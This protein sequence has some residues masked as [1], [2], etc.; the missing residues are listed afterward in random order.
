[1][2]NPRSW[3]RVVVLVF[4]SFSIS[5]DVEFGAKW[6]FRVRDLVI[7]MALDVLLEAVFY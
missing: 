2:G 6:E 3:L 4:A 1:V 7:L 5:I